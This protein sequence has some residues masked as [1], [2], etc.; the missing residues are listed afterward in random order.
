M[1]NFRHS[2]FCVIEQSRYKETLFGK[3][4]N[5]V[6]LT[7][8]LL[9]LVP[10]MFREHTKFLIAIDIFSCFLFIVDYIFRWITA[11]YKFGRKYGKWSF[12]IYPFSFMAIIDFLSILPT[13]S[14]ISNV[15][16]VLRVSRLL[17]I[18]RVLKVFRYYVPLRI[19]VSVLKRERKVLM[20]VLFFAMSYIFVIALIMFNVE[21]EQVVGNHLVFSNF[22]EAVYWSACTLTTVGYGDFCPVSTLGRSICMLSSLV[23]VAIIALPSGVITSAYMDEIRRRKK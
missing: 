7:A 17:R 6:M 13:L 19:I 18:I 15:F 21:C 10:L 9:G 14:T 3:V 4:Y 22:F 1:D 8:I 2:L 11:D 5:Y 20:T 23:G 12:V 16:K